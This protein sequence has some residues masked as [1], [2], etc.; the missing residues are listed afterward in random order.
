MTSV[1]VENV[2]VAQSLIEFYVSTYIQAQSVSSS[3]I[4]TQLQCFNGNIYFYTSFKLPESNYNSQSETWRD[5]YTV[6]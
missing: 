1:P 2:S 5:S 6:N 4:T 3:A